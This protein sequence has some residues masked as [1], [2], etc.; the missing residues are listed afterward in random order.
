MIFINNLNTT[1]FEPWFIPLDILAIICSTLDIGL[2]ILFLFTIIQD[3]TCHTVPMMLVANS[4]LAEL[5]LRIDI[6][7]ITQFK[8]QNDFKH[9][10]YQ[11]P[12][13]ISRSYIGYVTSAVLIYSYLLQA[14]YRYITAVYPT[15]LFWKSRRIQILFICI[16]WVFGFVYPFM[17]LFSNEIVYNADNQICQLPLQFSFSLIYGGLCIYIIP[18]SMIMMI[19]LKLYRYVKAMRRRAIPTTNPLF[20]ARRELK[21]VRH[22]ITVIAILFTMGCP[23]MIFLLMSI[24]NSIPKYH[25]RITYIFIDVPLLLSIIALFQFTQPLKQSIMKRI[26]RRPNRVAAIFVVIFLKR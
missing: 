21:M 11:D 5:I 19:Y 13:C 22:I 2:A 16:I 6:L 14:I 10:V 26:K 18:L 8:L 1:I 3:K 12:F 7:W 15:R 25:I 23:Y 4:C 20:R 17:F 24:F 9:I